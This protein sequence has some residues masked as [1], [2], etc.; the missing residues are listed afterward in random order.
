M[1][2][3][4]GEEASGPAHEVDLERG[5]ELVADRSLR[6]VEVDAVEDGIRRA[7]KP[8]Q[9]VKH[10]QDRIMRLRGVGLQAD[11]E[12]GAGP[13]QRQGDRGVAVEGDDGADDTPPPAA[14]GR[15]GDLR[16]PEPTVE[17]GESASI[18]DGGQGRA[19]IAADL[20]REAPAPA[21]LAPCP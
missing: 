17:V 6:A 7:A 18:L 16:A 14:G 5:L 10:S 15:L 9:G 4:P 20:D 2:R 1:V 3:V 11:L 19:R 21:R 12:D 8:V 13:D